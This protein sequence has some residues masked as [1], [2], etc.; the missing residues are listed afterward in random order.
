MLVKLEDVMNRESLDELNALFSEFKSFGM[1][2]LYPKELAAAYEVKTILNQREAAREEE[3]RG[4][5]KS[6]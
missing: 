2:T 1:E 6:V 5:K 4:S 3:R